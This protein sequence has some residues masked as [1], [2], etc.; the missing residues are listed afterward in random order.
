MSALSRLANTL[1][2][3]DLDECQSGCGAVYEHP[4]IQEQVQILIKVQESRPD[5]RTIEELQTICEQ[6]ICGIQQTLLPTIK[7]TT[8]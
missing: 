4:P 8:R 1:A 3:E 5:I 2:N 6:N 7:R